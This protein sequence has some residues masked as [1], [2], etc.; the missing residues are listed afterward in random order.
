MEVDEGVPNVVLSTSMLI[1]AYFRVGD[2]M[3]IFFKFRKPAS[4]V[5]LL[6]EASKA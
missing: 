6:K 4:S 2:I 5:F 1:T 3:I